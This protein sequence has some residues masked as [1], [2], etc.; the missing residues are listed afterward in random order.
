MKSSTKKIILIALTVLVIL[1]TNT[2]VHAMLSPKL[3]QMKEKLELLRIN[4]G[5]LRDSLQAL[6][7][8][9]GTAKESEAEATATKEKAEIEKKIAE[10]Q[11][12]I[13]RI[14][15]QEKAAAEK[16]AT[17]K[18][19]AEKLAAEKELA[20]AKTKEQQAQ[21]QLKTFQEKEAL[22]EETSNKTVAEKPAEENKP[23]AEAI[24]T[25]KTGTL[26]DSMM[27]L[28]KAS[29]LGL[30]LYVPKK[31]LGGSF[32][33]KKLFEDHHIFRF[34]W[35][36]DESTEEEF[37]LTGTNRLI[38]RAKG[39]E[40][41]YNYEI[42]LDYL[43]KLLSDAKS[44]IK[45]FLL[46]DD[47]ELPSIE[48]QYIKKEG[49][50]RLFTYAELQRV[51]TEEKLSHIHLPRKILVIK[52][53]KTGQYTPS[54]S[55]PDIIDNILKVY[56]CEIGKVR[57]KVDAESDDYE[58]IIFAHKETNSPKKLNEDVRKELIKLVTE[59]PFDVGNDNIF[60]DENGD[61]M[62]IDTEFKGESAEHTVP[63][64][65]RYFK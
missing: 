64:L 28:Y 43:P 33:L 49:L 35:D 12:E 53:R 29:H 45:S 20:E 11:A 59:A 63:K 42:E 9:L 18:A 16:L 4:L 44:I 23:V 55:A 21:A 6:K 51:I 1:N 24:P 3:A 56:V 10:E 14:A 26:K 61:A 38:A 54:K 36:I 57:V 58:L 2:S 37:W 30:P 52:N 15:A 31:E 13:K 7:E 39:Q 17:E 41:P 22:L 25:I 8:K 47:K 62:I 60:R 32:D 48:Q 34:R 5:N 27:K 40:Q 46:S 65:Q 50:N 19:A